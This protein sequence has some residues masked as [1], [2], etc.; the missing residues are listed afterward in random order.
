MR[1]GF[2]LDGTLA[3]MQS[4]LAREARELFPQ[5]DPA[6]LP[7]SAAIEESR[8]NLDSGEAN[9][10]VAPTPSA[11]L[12]ARQQ[13]MLWRAVRERQNFWETLDEIE[14]GA[15]A[16][17]AGL[18][19]DRKWEIIFLTSRPETKGTARSCNRTAGSRRTAFRRHRCLSCTHRAGRSRPLS[20]S[21]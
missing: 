2:D 3:D 8:A 20:S 12:S 21:M 19:R 5:V 10:D 1:L 6:T 9:A 4:A 16:R 15:L 17:L 18:V 14:P 7:R 13:Q 11:P